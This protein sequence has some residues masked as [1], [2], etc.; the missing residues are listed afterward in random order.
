[1]SKLIDNNPSLEMSTDNRVIDLP[2]TFAAR[3]MDVCLDG[4]VE[5]LVQLFEEM[6]RIGEPILPDMLNLPDAS[7]RVSPTSFFK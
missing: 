3:F 7:G 2:A 1:M 5:D 6:A 4:D